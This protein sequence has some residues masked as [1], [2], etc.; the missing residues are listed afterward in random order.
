MKKNAITMLLAGAVTATVLAGCGNKT[1]GEAVTTP[2][3]TTAPEATKAPVETEESKVTETPEATEAPKATETPEATEMPKVTE[4][5]ETSEV[6]EAPKPTEAPEAT[7]SPK[8]TEVPEATESPKPTETP[9]ATEAPKATEAPAVTETPKATETPAPTKSPAET[10]TAAESNIT[11]GQYKGL[12]LYKVD[13]SDIAQEIDNMMAGYVE[14]V[15]VNRPAKE[16]DIVNINYVGKKD[17]IAFDGGTDDSEEG[18]NLG[19][20]SHSFIDGF[21]EGLIGATA[22]E[23]RDLNLTFPENYHSAELAGQAVVFTVTVNYVQ[24]EVIP[25]F[26]D[27]FVKENFGFAT[28]AEYVAA[29]EDEMNKATFYDQIFAALVETSTVKNYPADLIEQEK[30]GVI[31]YYM[32]YVEMYSA[33]LG[34]DFETTLTY[35]FDF[36]SQEALEKFAEEYAYDVIKEQLVLS[37][38]GVKEG[39]TVSEEEYQRRAL[40][41]AMYYGYED[42][43]S[44]EMDYGAEQ[45]IN[46]VKTD[47]IVDYIVSQSVIK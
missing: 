10:D 30:Q 15:A 42:V 1:T 26:T 8:A 12:T 11:L 47:Y 39:L 37:E 41:Y 31:D 14:L 9:A 18:Y 23:V 4:T 45:I 5:P 34:M 36:E 25:E 16:G 35:M 29:L 33:Y 6:T 20:G 32:Y 27:E 38:V 44:F 40:E 19:L 24:E 43:A 13:S 21:E 17:G 3:E 46:A 2:V 22:G 28:A 7:E